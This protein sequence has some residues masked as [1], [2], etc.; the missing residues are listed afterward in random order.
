MVAI[1]RTGALGN[2]C[3]VLP[4]SDMLDSMSGAPL[5]S[6]PHAAAESLSG[7]PT[8]W[9]DLHFILYSIITPWRSIVVGA[10]RATGIGFLT[11]VHALMPTVFALRRLS[12]DRALSGRCAIRIMQVAELFN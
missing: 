2:I 1:P 10:S 3:W 7:R 11:L 6:V 9:P 5:R 4:E 12:P 8:Y